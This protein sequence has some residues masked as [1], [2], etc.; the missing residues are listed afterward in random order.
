MIKAEA[1]KRVER[2]LIPQGMQVARCYSMVYI[3]TVEWEYKG[4]NKSTPKVRL[5]WEFP[6]ELRVFK[7]ENGEQ[8]MV[9]SN[10]YTLS[11]YEKANLRKDLENWR[12]AKFTD[13]EADDFDITKLLGV[14]CMINV[15]HHEAKNGN[16]YANVGSINPLM[17]GMECPEQVNPSF[18]FN[19]TDC[20][21][22]EWVEDQPEFIA[23]MIK[24]TPEYKART[25]DLSAAEEL[26]RIATE[27]FPA[28]GVGDIP[29]EEEQPIF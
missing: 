13:T 9:I 5:T 12:G 17:K 1:P 19:Y 24:S 21:N 22:S 14:P 27:G 7:E 20:F 25:M 16:I 6:N 11:M 15:I 3:G 4:K 18:E 23:D 29:P 2:E 10:E 8:P 28:Q 26:K